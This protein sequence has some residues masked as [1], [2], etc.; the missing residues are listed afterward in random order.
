MSRKSEM[1]FLIIATVVILVLT[2]NAVLTDGMWTLSTLC[3]V[4]ALA[5]MIVG[6]IKFIK[7]REQ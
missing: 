4:A 3:F 1:I 5:C 2:V 6:W 7:N